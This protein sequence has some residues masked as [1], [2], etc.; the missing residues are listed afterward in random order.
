MVYVCVVHQNRMDTGLL[1]L[2]TTRK[3]VFELKVVV[4]HLL[5]ISGRRASESDVS[6]ISDEFQDSIAD[7]REDEVET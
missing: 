3:L 5:E 4:E 7:C 6:E 2:A 1:L